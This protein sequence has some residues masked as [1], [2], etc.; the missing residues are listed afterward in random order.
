[1]S[2]RAWL[3]A[4]VALAVLPAG[5]DAQTYR[6]PFGGSCTSS[7][8]YVTSYY[9]LDGGGGI[10]DWN[11]GTNTYDGHHGTDFGVGSWPGM[12][13]GRD[14]VAGADGEVINAHDGEFD[15]CTSGSCAGGGGYGNWVRL[16]HA[17]GKTT[18]YGHMKNGS[19]AVA[20]GDRVTC[21]Q[22]LGQVGSS[23]YST[24]PHLHFEVRTSGGSADDP[25]TGPCG[26]PLC[27]W[28]EQG[29]YDGLPGVTCETAATDAD[30]DGYPAGTDCNNGDG[31][32]HPGATEV[33]NGVDD[34]CDG[35]TDEDV[36]NRC[37]TCGPEPAEICDGVD[38]DCD[39]TTDEDCAAEDAGGETIGDVPGDTRRDGLSLDV[40]RYDAG[41]DA[42]GADGGGEGCGCSTSGRS[43]RLALLP[44]VVL[45]TVALRLSLRRRRHRRG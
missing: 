43:T 36:L 25:F 21:G 45:A 17:D 10:Q 8:C 20:V 23:G 29:A 26:G 3:A 15:R 13:A 16:Q 9:D 40:P 27:Y 42:A 5:A 22:R 6:F 2:P 11:C 7:S 34:N 18:T 19:V 4:S 12:D 44:V 37:G 30:G 28:V 1:V 41:G 38:N 32:I 39:G 33:C 31:S 24:G 35:A 14:I